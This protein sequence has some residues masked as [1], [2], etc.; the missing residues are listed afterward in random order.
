MAVKLI[1]ASGR[2]VSVEDDVKSWASGRPFI[3]LK[4]LI[5]LI[6]LIWTK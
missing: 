1:W 5:E 4:P 6:Y 3:Y 2:P